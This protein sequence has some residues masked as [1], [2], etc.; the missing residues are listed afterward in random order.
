MTWPDRISVYHKL[1][2]RPTPSTDA[3]VLDVM[4]LSEVRQRP[5]ARCLEDCVVYNY[6]TARKASLP[7]WMLD[8]FE[9]TFDLQEVAKR[10][11]GAKIE[12]LLGRVEALEKKTWDR[13][14]AIE[15]FGGR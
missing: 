13:P 3:M 10:E 8:Q 5:A 14:D 12:G 1:R 7:P 11:N 2:S 6:R 4:I 9:K 15:Q